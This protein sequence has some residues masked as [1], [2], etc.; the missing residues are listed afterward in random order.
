MTRSDFCD[1]DK[2]VA[3]YWVFKKNYYENDRYLFL[4]LPRSVYQWLLLLLSPLWFNPVNAVLFFS[5]WAD[6]WAKPFLSLVGARGLDFTLRM[7]KKRNFVQFK[8]AHLVLSTVC[9]NRKALGKVCVSRG[10]GIRCCQECAGEIG[11]HP[12]E[13]GSRQARGFLC[14]GKTSTL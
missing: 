6:G 3:T 8:F 7:R 12:G 4:F 2:L 1:S 9:L 14:W 13:Q 5:S 10:T 11:Q